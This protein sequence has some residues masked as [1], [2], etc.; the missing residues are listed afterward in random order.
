MSVFAPS[1]RK[2]CPYYENTIRASSPTSSAT[3]S[4][5]TAEVIRILEDADGLAAYELNISCPNVKQGGIQFGSD[6]AMVSQVVGLA[7][8]AAT[9]RPLW[10]KLSPLVTDIRLIAK[11][12]EEAG[13]DGL[14]VANT[15]PAMA[16]DFRTGKSRLGARPAG[17]LAR[18]FSQ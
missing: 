3:P 4:T 10:V 11:A 7:R 1:L 18:P 15:Y 17:F 5:T 6:P 8:K 16:V 2:N 12:A 13:A 14:T 9:K